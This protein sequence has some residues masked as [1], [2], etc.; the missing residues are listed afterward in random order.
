MAIFD[1]IVARVMFA[2]MS[3]VAQRH[4]KA[5]DAY[6]KQRLGWRIDI[7]LALKQRAQRSAALLADIATY[8]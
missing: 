7:A 3:R 6:M 1:Y 2:Y 5:Y 4:A 8:L